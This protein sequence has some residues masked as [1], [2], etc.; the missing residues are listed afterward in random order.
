VTDDRPRPA[1]P[2]IRSVCHLGRFPTRSGPGWALVGQDGGQ[3][4]PLGP[5]GENRLFVFSDTLLT[6][7]RPVSGSAPPPARRPP[8]RGYLGILANTAARAQNR[9]LQQALAG[10]DYFLDGRSAPRE[11]L[12]SSADERREGIR[13]WPQH[14]LLVN[15]SV[16]LFY[17]GVRAVTGSTW[18]FVNEGTG[19]AVLDPATGECRRQVRR[20]GRGDWIFWPPRTD[21]LHFGVQVLREGELAYVF[22][23]RRRG[24]QVTAQLAR[25]EVCRL[26]QPSAYRYLA[27]TAPRWTRRLAESCDL[28]PSGSQFSVSFNGHL[29]QYLM[30]YVDLLDGGLYLR[31]ADAPWGPY[32]DPRRVARVPRQQEAYLGFEHASFAGE[33]GRQILVSYCEPR[34]SQSSLVAVRLA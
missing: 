31:A 3:S 33:D 27:S 23:S 28:G 32:G 6:A 25:V 29:R 2:E 22:A 21:D 7:A 16:V 8:G 10:L 19:L 11:I 9:D 20:G 13:F 14:G 26:S 30:T 17:M 15:D 12:P 34:F 1:P 4:I 5:L 24:M 18:G